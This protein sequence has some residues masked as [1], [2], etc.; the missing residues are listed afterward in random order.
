MSRLRTAAWIG[1]LGLFAL[2]LAS[3]AIAALIAVTPGVA[4]STSPLT[5]ATGEGRRADLALGATPPDLAVGAQTAARAS[6]LAP[7]D[8][9]ARLR[10]AYIDALDG[11]LGPEGVKAL[12]LSYE[13]LPFDHYVAAWRVRFALDHWDQ[14][15]PTLRARVES[16][17]FAF[18]KTTRRSEMIAALSSVRS[19]VG[20]VPATFW[21]LRMQREHRRRVAER[22]MEASTR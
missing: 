9:S 20:V 1:A 12:E 18:A 14:L 19:P 22:R 6:M 4:S 11:N 7:Y 2:G 5:L 15:T 21:R 17:A 13:L 8:S 10:L 16:E 3:V